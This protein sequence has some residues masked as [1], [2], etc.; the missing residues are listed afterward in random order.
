MMEKLII[1]IVFILLFLKYSYSNN[2]DEK[3]RFL[4]FPI[5]GGTA[6]VVAGT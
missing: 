3:G 1:Q 5:G 6:K 2:S 4:T